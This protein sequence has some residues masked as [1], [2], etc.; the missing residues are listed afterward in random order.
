[1]FKLLYD[2]F[3]KELK[4]LQIVNKKYEIQKLL[5]KGSYGLTYLVKNLE[6]NTYA[7]LKQNRKRKRSKGKESFRNEA[8][9]LRKLKHHSIP[10]LYDIFE[11]EDSIFLVLE[12]KEGWTVEQLIFEKGKQ[13]DELDA[14]TLLRQVLEVVAFIHKQGIVHLDLRTPNILF[15]NN[16]VHIIDFGLAKYISNHSNKGKNMWKRPVI[17]NDLY[18]LGH[19][20]LFLLYSSFNPDPD[21]K[22]KDSWLNEL[23]LQPESKTIVKRLL[24]LEKPYQSASEVI[25]DIDRFLDKSN[26]ESAAEQELFEVSDARE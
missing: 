13:Y 19:F 23:S 18:E 25:A 2:L 24:Q 7:V 17:E 3:E 10:N 5:G 21:G 11:W 4:P 1:M 20:T 26:K 15:D 6:H 9:M 8:S 12:R 22:K 14:F 16:K